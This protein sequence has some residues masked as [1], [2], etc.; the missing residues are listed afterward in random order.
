MAVSFDKGRRHVTNPQR[1]PGEKGRPTSVRV[2]RLG[3]NDR[4]VDYVKPVACPNRMSADPVGDAVHHAAQFR[5]RT[6]ADLF[7]NMLV[8]LVSD[9]RDAMPDDGSI[10]IRS[11]ARKIENGRFDQLVLEVSDTGEVIPA[12]ILDHVTEP[13]FTTK[14]D[15]HGMGLGL[16][17]VKH[18][19]DE[20][21]GHLSLAS[22]VGLGTRVTMVLLMTPQAT[23]T[24]P[25]R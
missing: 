9:A 7:T 8:S 16:P 13:F 25:L 6:E 3:P 11:R 12:A 10:T 18:F 17:S 22:T 14:P 20:I 1:K 24:T 5:V 19:L 4:L 2:G 15:G 21:G 23:S